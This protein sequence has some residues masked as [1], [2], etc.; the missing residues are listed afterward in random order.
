ML[1]PS[2]DLVAGGNRAPVDEVLVA[3]CVSVR[4]PEILRRN[5]LKADASAQKIGKT[6]CG[7][8]HTDMIVLPKLHGAWPTMVLDLKRLELM[9]RA[10]VGLSDIA[11][12]ADEF[13]RVASMDSPFRERVA[14]RFVATCGRPGLPDFDRVCLEQ[15]IAAAATPVG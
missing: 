1:T 8:G 6:L 11:G 3:R 14:W 10:K 2:C 15:D 13:V 5:N 12:A 4:D 7:D 9:E